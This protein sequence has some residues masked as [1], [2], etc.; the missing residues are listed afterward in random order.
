[1]CI[2][3]GTQVISS[4]S[5]W[6][7]Y[8]PP[9]SADHW[10]DGRSAKEVACAWLEGDGNSMP[11]EVHEALAVHPS[12]GPVVSWE[13][14]PEA[15]LRFDS[16][17]GEPRNC[18]L[19]VYASD[20]AGPYVLAIEAKADETY[21]ETVAKAFAAALERRIKNPRS[22]GIARIDLLAGSF[23]RPRA[24]GAPK[25]ANL[26]YQLLTA[27]AGAVAEAERRKCSRAVMLVHEFV[28]S[29]TTDAKHARNASDLAAFLSRLSGEC[30]DAVVNGQLYGPFPFSAAGIQLFVGKVTRYLR[31]S[32]VAMK[33]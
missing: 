18:D 10:V 25:T 28:T 33:T 14:E 22:N 8:A 16:F 23:L 29:A 9:K 26:R 19:A 2:S 12:F 31:K 1:M 32:A 17:L 13:A 20:A 6:L 27:C 15:K 3:K 5:E 24:E 11:S 30:C 21:G 4:L 7:E